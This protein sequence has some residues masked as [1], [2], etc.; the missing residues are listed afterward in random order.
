MPLHVALRANNIDIVE[1]LLAS[2]A[3]VE[4]RSGEE[5]SSLELACS[6]GL[7]EAQAAILSYLSRPDMRT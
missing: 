4:V 5:L 6:C 3:D 1:T 2:G 7:E